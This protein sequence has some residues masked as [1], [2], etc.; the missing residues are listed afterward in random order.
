MQSKS[1]SF[2][3]NDVQYFLL[4][5]IVFQLQL[6]GG[7]VS[8]V[9]KSFFG[10]HD[11]SFLFY[12]QKDGLGMWHFSGSFEVLLEVEYFGVGGEFD[13]HFGFAYLDVDS[14]EFFFL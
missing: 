6:W 12:E 8:V 5:G 10:A 3:D 4:V 9:N 14:Y 1:V 2:S 11:F 13:L 7:I